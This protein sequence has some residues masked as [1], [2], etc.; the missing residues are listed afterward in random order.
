MPYDPSRGWY[1]AATDTGPLDNLAATTAPTADN[2]ETEGYSVGS[3]WVDV[4][5]DKVYACTNAAEGAAEW[6]ETTSQ[7]TTTLA[8][9]TDVNITNPQPSEALLMGGY[10][11]YE[12]GVAYAGAKPTITGTGIS[13]GVV[14]DVWG[15]NTNYVGIDK[16]GTVIWEFAEAQNLAGMS[17]AWHDGAPPQ[18]VKVECSTNGSDWVQV[19]L[20]QDL[21][22]EG[23]G[24]STVDY[25]FDDMSRTATFWRL[26]NVDTVSDGRIEI[27]FRDFYVAVGSGSAITNQPLTLAGLTDVDL[28][29]IAD[30]DSLK[31]SGGEVV[32]GDAVPTALGDLA[33]VV[34]TEASHEQVLRLNAEHYIATDTPVDVSPIPDMTGTPSG[35]A[36]WPGVAGSIYRA[37]E[38]SYVQCLFAEP[39]VF[40]GVSWSQPNTGER[41]ST[42]KVECSNNGTD[43][44]TVL[45]VTSNPYGDAV[46]GIFE[47]NDVGQSALYWRLTVID[48]TT[49]W[50]RWHMDEIIWYVSQAEGQ[51]EAASFSVITDLASKTDGDFAVS[52]TSWADVDSSIDLTVAAAAGDRLLI[53][54]NARWIDGGADEY[55]FL[56]A[57]TMVSGSPVNYVSGAGSSGEGVPSWAITNSDGKSSIGGSVMYEVQAGDISGGEVTLR[58]RK[59]AGGITPN[60]TVRADTTVPLHWNVVNLR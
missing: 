60:L 11:S 37:G 20:G 6:I 9:L 14:T 36:V 44:T 53:G 31:Y 59:K 43:W 27:N 5:A 51:W 49:V 41:P 42:F 2:D 16:A 3:R 45:P 10:A 56:D 40:S 52:D 8:G 19:W 29:G 50:N 54:L 13:F 28:T 26:T 57:V 47:F 48:S 39:K 33:D 58:L 4:V 18:D 30:G 22:A 46:T 55:G 23:L 25:D 17:I 1:E 15:D 38:G 32:K 7:G 24:Y 35:T 34:V 21:D 12:R